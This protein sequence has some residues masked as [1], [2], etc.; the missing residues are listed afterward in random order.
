MPLLLSG[1]SGSL[2]RLKLYL[3]FHL[4]N[5]DLLICFSDLSTWE[6]REQQETSRA[7]QVK[8]E[9]EELQS[10]EQ[11]VETELQELEIVSWAEK[12]QLEREVRL[13]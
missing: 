7:Q 5:L 1:T 2:K 12:L 6:S 3:K 13:Q 4:L 10:L 8:Q 9:L 11:Q